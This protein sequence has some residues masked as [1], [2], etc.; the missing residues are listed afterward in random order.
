MY[1]TNRVFLIFQTIKD[2]KITKNNH[3]N[4]ILLL[5]TIQKKFLFNLWMKLISKLCWKYIAISNHW[6]LYLK[7]FITI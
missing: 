1:K 7:L 6:K 2:W 3:Y 5:T 4:I